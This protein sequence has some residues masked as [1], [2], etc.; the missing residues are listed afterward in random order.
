MGSQGRAER[1]VSSTAMGPRWLNV[2]AH[3]A[4]TE[5]EG[6][7]RRYALWV[8]GCPLRCPGCCNPHM[9]EDREAKVESV[10]SVIESILSQRSQIEGVTF[11]GGEPFWQA[12]ALTQVAR[13]VRQA[14]L[15][16][17]VFTGLTRR[18]IERQEREDWRAFLNEIDLLI[19]GP[20]IK[21][22]HVDDRRWIGSS[23]QGVHLLS[24]RY[25]HLSEELGQGWDGGANTIE[26]RLTGGELTINGFPEESIVA[27]S[28]A[29]ITKKR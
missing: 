25:A 19:D 13:A 23:N 18:F 21:S 8:Q 6:P 2:A 14:G 24:E 10:E 5:A 27:L 15:S 26:L 28:R 20:Y 29:S 11:I 22:K 17:M 1:F 3:V 9:L 12:E 16:V 7:G 4:K